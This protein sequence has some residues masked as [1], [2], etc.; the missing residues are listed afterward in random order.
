ML[1]VASV[2]IFPP[3]H[4]VLHAEADMPFHSAMCGYIGTMA[5]KHGKSSWILLVASNVT[6]CK[7]T[8]N[9]S[10]WRC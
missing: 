7:L 8:L 5:E 3:A 1:A 4:T 6:E 2:V 9:E 10:I